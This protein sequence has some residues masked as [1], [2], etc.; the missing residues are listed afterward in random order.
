MPKLV[1]GQA[2]NCANFQKFRNRA[3]HM[4]GRLTISN[5]IVQ[6]ELSWLP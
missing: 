6:I 1:G 5:D 3:L 4:N 2:R